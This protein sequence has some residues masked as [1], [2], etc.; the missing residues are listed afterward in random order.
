MLSWPPIGKIAAHSAYEVFSWCLIVSLVFS[1]LGFWCGNLFLNAPFPDAYL[2]LSVSLE[3]VD[4]AKVVNITKK[5]HEFFC[6][7]FSYIKSRAY[8]TY[9]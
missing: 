4:N 7:R 8:D 9:I 5:F 2:Y 1:R 3:H 6:E